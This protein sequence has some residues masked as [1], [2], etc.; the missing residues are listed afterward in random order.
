[1]ARVSRWL[2][3]T[4]Y[5]QKWLVLGV[6]IGTAAGVGAIV[7]YEALIACTHLFL[8][9]LAG[10]H[11]PTPVGEGGQRALASF[12]RPWAL[13]LVVGSGALLGAILVFQFAPEAEGH[14]TDAAI[15]A[16]H[17]NPRGIRFR[18]VVVKIVAS[19]LTIGSGGSGGREGPTG[20]ISAGFA[21]LLA[22]ELDLSPADARIAV[23]AGI[24]SGIGAIFGAPLGGAVLA[25]EILYRD[26]FEAEALLPSFIASI[27][28]YVIFGAAVGYTPLFGFNSSYHFTDPSHLLWFALIGVLGG[29]VGL[30]Y[31][32]G[33]YGISD[34]FGRLW[35]PRWSKPAIG[36]V[37]VGC[38]ALAIPEVLGTGYGWI[39]QGLGHQLLTMPLWIVLILP[40]ARILATGLSI[41]SG[42]SGG[43]FG[44]GMVIGA[45]I[46]ASVWRLF[47]PIVPS[48]GHNPA[49]FVIVGMMCCFGSISR[50]PLAVML[51]VAEM[52]GSVSILAP[53]MIAVGLAWF[54]VERD[55]DT[56]YR[57]QL[58][59][60]T[61]APA[62]RLLTGMPILSTVSVGQA[63]AM[64]RVVVSG[65][66]SVNDVR[67]QIEHAGVTGA[68][69]I[70]G[71]GRFEGTVALADLRTV[72]RG[73]NRSLESLIDVSA[74]TVSGQAHLDV[75]LD[76][77][78]TSADHWVTILDADRKVLG[79]VAISD[80]VRG[81]RLGL[82]A[83]LQK[84]NTAGEPGGTDRVQIRSGSP[85]VGET[86]RRSGIPVSVIVTAIQ[87]RRNLIVPD[88]GTLLETGDE[89]I[90]IGQSS[91]INLIREVAAGRATDRPGRNHYADRDEQ[92]PGFIERGPDGSR[93]PAD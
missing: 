48:M 14:G 5:L 52:T 70:D 62:R 7:F 83:G 9:V 89:L 71:E 54:I 21:S 58:K 57:S 84:V 93:P 61:D 91:D 76:A 27:V 75:A 88:G 24:G 85:L 10:Y 79:T 20:Q 47:E 77:L 66:T 87:R 44:P 29:S 34:I 90:L 55:D 31:A 78:A 60:R 49:P 8:G 81:Y 2:S 33:F 69:V 80:V 53:A 73:D 59:N 86:L 12:S 36:G 32:K 65:G 46:G 30:L 56:I 39:Q 16:V 68:P 1:M 3:S 15:S 82:L 26:D 25:T 72:R 42:G 45:F 35:L 63:M 22:R 38:I 50:A 64:P 11:V 43:I 19:A 40:L 6:L 28:A 37:L 51:M 67:H 74:P 17:H 13:P 92:S 23:M 4:S 18:A 41:G